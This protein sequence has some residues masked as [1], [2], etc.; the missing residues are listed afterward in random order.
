MPIAQFEGK[1]LVFNNGV[2]DVQQNGVSVVDEN[3]VAH[4][5][6]SS[7]GN[8][9]IDN[10]TI[11]KNAEQELEVPFDNDTIFR[12]SEDGFIKAKEP[13]DAKIILC[14][15]V[16]SDPAAPVGSFTL[17]QASNKTI[18][19]PIPEGGGSSLPTP[20][21]GQSDKEQPL[22]AMWDYSG[23]EP[24]KTIGFSPYKWAVPTPDVEDAGKALMVGLH[25]GEPELFW[26]GESVASP[27]P[28]DDGK[29]LTA[30]PNDAYKT[31]WKKVLPDYTA[32]DSDRMLTVKEG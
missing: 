15:Q 3:K 25:E 12:D 2:V 18:T 13:S 17:N 7:E 8:V 30:T 32:S 22:V 19:I 20:T 29:V 14:T 24:K 21:D 9:K 27:T 28:S 1:A 4:I 10:L 6:T 26:T 5:T 16:G 11:I 23:D 31:Q